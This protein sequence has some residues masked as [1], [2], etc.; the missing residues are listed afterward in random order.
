MKKTVRKNP[1]RSAH[2]GTKGRTEI[3]P[4][5]FDR[6]VEVYHFRLKLKKLQTSRRPHNTL[7]HK[8]KHAKTTLDIGTIEIFLL[9]ISWKS[10]V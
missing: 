10:V 5:S 4:S 9:R 3:Q 7:V 8:N 1:A 2:G 6:C